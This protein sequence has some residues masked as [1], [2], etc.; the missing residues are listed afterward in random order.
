MAIS[1]CLLGPLPKGDSVRR[2]WI[3]WKIAYKKKLASIG[4]FVFTDGDA[5]RDETRQLELVGHDAYL[6]KS[7]DVVVVNAESKLGAGTAQEMVIAKYYSKP[8]VTVLPKNTHHRKTGVVF[9]GKAIGDWVHPFISVLSDEVVENLDDCAKWI[10]RYA[11]APQ[12]AKIKDITI[13]DDA[14]A[15]YLSSK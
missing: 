14:V 9:D 11:S 3:D 1:V 12:N 8:V 7:C 6:V 5:W 2:G 4:D 10:M 15:A 13:V